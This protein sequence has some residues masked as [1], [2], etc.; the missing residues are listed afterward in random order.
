[1]AYSKAVGWHSNESV[2]AIP[3]AIQATIPYLKQMEIAMNRADLLRDLIHPAVDRVP[4][5]DGA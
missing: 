3:G 2:V 5:V 4:V 1:M